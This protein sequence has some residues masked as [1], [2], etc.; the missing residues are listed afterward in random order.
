MGMQLHCTWLC[1]QLFYL[2]KTDSFGRS[3]NPLT[4]WTEN[5]RVTKRWNAKLESLWH[6]IYFLLLSVS[7]GE[8]SFGS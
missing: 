2:S 4:K 7:D 5:R 8:G 6:I 1:T 3:V